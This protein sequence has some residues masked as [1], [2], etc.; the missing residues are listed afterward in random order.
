M[1]FLFNRY[2]SLMVELNAIIRKFKEKG[3][4]TGWTYLDVP[5]DLANELKPDCKVS[6]RVQGQIDGVSFGGI[7]LAPMGEGDF[8]LPLKK[9]LQKKIGKKEGAM[10]SLKIAEDKDFKIEMPLDL[11]TCLADVDC[12]LTQFSA[13]PKSHQNYYFNWINAAKTE[14]TRV[15]RITQIIEAMEL[16]MNYGEM[17]RHNKSKS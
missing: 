15:K 5:Q 7:A 11:E 3:E 13:L 8:I 1:S 9:E 10:V 14:P 16:K 12:A 17:I 2:I 4:K 6:F